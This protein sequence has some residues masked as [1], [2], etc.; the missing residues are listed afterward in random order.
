MSNLP[1][2]NPARPFLSLEELLAIKGTPTF[3]E[4]IRRQYAALAVWWRA[5]PEET[6]YFEQL[7]AEVWAMLPEYDWGDEPPS[8][9]SFDSK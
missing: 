6:A 9:Q 5:H 4:E 7:Q 3:D 1:E 8:F 2:V